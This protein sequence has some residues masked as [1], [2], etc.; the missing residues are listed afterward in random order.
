MLL[1]RLV[2]HAAKIGTI[3][4]HVTYRF[5]REGLAG[6]AREA[7]AIENYGNIGIA[8]MASSV[9]VKGGSEAHNLA[10]I[11]NKGSLGISGVTAT[12]RGIVPLV[13]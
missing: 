10:L 3:L 5:G 13:G 9:E 7:I 6:L 2:A 4:Q 8:V 11:G 1:V 12:Y